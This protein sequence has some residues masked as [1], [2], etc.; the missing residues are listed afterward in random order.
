MAERP[1]T[2]NVHALVD[3]VR[4]RND[5][6]AG[7]HHHITGGPLPVPASLPASDPKES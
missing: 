7:T 5:V 4:A 3:A 6:P 2:N 1:D